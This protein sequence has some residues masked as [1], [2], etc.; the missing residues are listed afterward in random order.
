MFEFD[1]KTVDAL[2]LENEQFRRMYDKHSALKSMVGD[3]N[4][5]AVAM[6]PESLEDLKK[7]KLLLKDR[8]AAMIAQY[9]TVCH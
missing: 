8:M 3:A 5:G 4:A 7:E 1:Q 2:L 9:K 6:P